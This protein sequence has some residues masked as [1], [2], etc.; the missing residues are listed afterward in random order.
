MWWPCHSLVL[1]GEVGGD[2]RKHF[3]T[4]DLIGVDQVATLEVQSPALSRHEL[5][6]LGEAQVTGHLGGVHAP[7]VEGAAARRTEQAGRVA[8]D[9]YQSGVGVRDDVRDAREQAPGRS[10]EHTS[11]LQS[12]MRIS[13]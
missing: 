10:E 5:R 7:G 4:V 6:Q 3:I 13:Y 2:L 9:W 11:A 1:L 12:L 8:R